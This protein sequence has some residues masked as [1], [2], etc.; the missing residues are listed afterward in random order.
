MQLSTSLP[1]RLKTIFCVGGQWKFS[2]YDGQAF[3]LLVSTY[4]FCS[5]QL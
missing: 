4:L 2:H 3:A 5:N 1:Q